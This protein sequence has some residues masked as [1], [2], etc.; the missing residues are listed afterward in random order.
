MATNTRH[1]AWSSR[2]LR[3]KK[4]HRNGEKTGR[5]TRVHLPDREVSKHDESVA[6][7]GRRGCRV[8]LPDEQVHASL[9]Q[10]LVP[11]AQLAWVGWSV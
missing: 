10:S 5:R 6:P 7:Y 3:K 8:Q 4:K 11:Q 9:G 2:N 1:T